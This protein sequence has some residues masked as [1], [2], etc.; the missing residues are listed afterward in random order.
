[1]IC[2][3]QS[4]R[5]GQRIDECSGE[6]RKTG[7][8]FRANHGSKPTSIQRVAPVGQSTGQPTGREDF[9]Q[10]SDVESEVT[11]WVLIGREED[12]I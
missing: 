8:V 9:Y 11:H 12:G 7:V 10:D 1:M 5:S 4:K 2:S 6:N 3:G